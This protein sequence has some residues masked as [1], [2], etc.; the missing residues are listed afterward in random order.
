[1]SAGESGGSAQGGD[2]NAPVKFMRQM[3]SLDYIA[4]QSPLA[5]AFD[6]RLAKREIPGHK[7]PACN[8]V[9]CPPKGFC[10]MCV[11]S[12][13]DED[14]VMVKDTGTVTTF[15]VITPIQYYGQE[16]R[17]EDYVLANI[18][19]DGSD[20]TIMM[21]RLG[22]IANGDVRGGLRVV[23]VWKDTMDG[24]GMG[25]AIEHWSPSGEPDADKAHFEE[26]I[27]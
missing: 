26:H 9:Y 2:D 5:L 17:G 19:L 7:C 12:T 16:E 13:G 23:A 14:E 22:D 25:G 21:Q 10:P 24:A 6:A 3:V 8:L 27:L 20:Q 1:M 4:H 15:T 18:L 11:V